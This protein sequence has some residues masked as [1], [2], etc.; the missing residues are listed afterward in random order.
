MEGDLKKKKKDKVA[1][2]HCQSADGDFRC[3]SYKDSST[4]PVPNQ[5][6]G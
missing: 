2:A 3:F 4:S 1:K 6:R 5:P